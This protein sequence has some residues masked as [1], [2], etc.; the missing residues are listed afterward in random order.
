MQKAIEESSNQ[1]KIKDEGTSNVIS[2][3]F[4]CNQTIILNMNEVLK[5]KVNHIVSQA[6]PMLVMYQAILKKYNTINPKQDSATFEKLLGQILEKLADAK[7]CVKFQKVYQDF[8]D[9]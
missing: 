4:K 8:F 9:I 2:A 5:D 3:E 7:Q 1:G 6:I